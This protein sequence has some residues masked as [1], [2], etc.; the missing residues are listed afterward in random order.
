MISD[1]GLFGSE[2]EVELQNLPIPAFVTQSFKS[3]QA[4][5][6]YLRNVDWHAVGGMITYDSSMLGEFEHPLAT[7]QNNPHLC[8]ELIS[9]RGECKEIRQLDYGPT[10][11]A[12]LLCSWV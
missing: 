10:K 2:N 4:Y 6:N 3:M 12:M 8:F 1:D 11:M 5:G 9:Y 7:T